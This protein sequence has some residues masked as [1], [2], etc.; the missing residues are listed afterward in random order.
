M[1][2]TLARLSAQSH[3]DAALS[4]LQR[5]EASPWCGSNLR[6]MVDQQFLH[7]QK[8][9]ELRLG[10]SSRICS[11]YLAKARMAL[12]HQTETPFRLSSRGMMLRMQDWHEP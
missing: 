10:F 1:H 2:C 6:V 12:S 4:A 8:N 5:H 3:C 7:S 11:E 9:T